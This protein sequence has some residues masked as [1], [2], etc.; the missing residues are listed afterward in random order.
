MRVWTW[1]MLAMGRPLGRAGLAEMS[2]SCPGRML[3]GGEGVEGPRP[4]HEDRREPWLVAQSPA[5]ELSGVPWPRVLGREWPSAPVPDRPVWMENGAPT[6]SPPGLYWDNWV[7]VFPA[8]WCSSR[9]MANGS[10]EH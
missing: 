8:P 10:G 3:G 6:T 1:A 4:Q 9:L 7:P 2:W 5:L